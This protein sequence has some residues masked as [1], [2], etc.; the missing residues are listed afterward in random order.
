MSNPA[1]RREQH[2][3]GQNHLLYVTP[4]I[5]SYLLRLLLHLQMRLLRE[6]IK[7]LQSQHEAHISVV[8]EKYQQ[9]KLQIGEYH[10]SLEVAM[11]VP[12][13]TGTLQAKMLR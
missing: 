13:S 11:V 2:S 8:L 6:K 10:E 12:D 7:E 1:D 4:V 9:L 5:L 3:H